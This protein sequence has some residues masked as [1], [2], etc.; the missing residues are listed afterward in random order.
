[1]KKDKWMIVLTLLVT[2]INLVL[3][4]QYIKHNF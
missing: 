2:T 3:F 4:Y 1:M